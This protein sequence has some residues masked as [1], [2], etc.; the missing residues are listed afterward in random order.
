MPS[1]QQTNLQET[2]H[3]CTSLPRRRQEQNSMPPPTAIRCSL[4]FRHCH[5][6]LMRWRQAHIRRRWGFLQACCKRWRSACVGRR[7]WGKDGSA[8]T[9]VVFSYPNCRSSRCR[10][11]SI[12]QPTSSGVLNRWCSR[13]GAWHSWT[14]RLDGIRSCASQNINSRGFRFAF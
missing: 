14:S 8:T 9:L 7:R 2:E 4:P 5:W 1:L 11:S 3:W 6:P 10:S 12:W 13:I